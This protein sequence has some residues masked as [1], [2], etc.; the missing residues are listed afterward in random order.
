MIRFGSASLTPDPCL[1]GPPRCGG[2]TLLSGT[3]AIRTARFRSC[4]CLSEFAGTT[5]HGT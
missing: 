4:S 3:T 5:H 1:G 2:P